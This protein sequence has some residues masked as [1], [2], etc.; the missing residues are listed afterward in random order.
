MRL[1]L[2]LLCGLMVTGFSGNASATPPPKDDLKEESAEKPTA[3]ATPSALD[4]NAPRQ[5]HFRVLPP[6]I[7]PVQGD[8]GGITKAAP[9]FKTTSHLALDQLSPREDY[10]YGP[11]FWNGVGIEKV[12]EFLKSPTPTVGSATFQNMILKAVLTPT[13]DT[14]ANIDL[15]S[16]R[17]SKLVDMGAY[18]DALNLYKMNENAPPSALAARAG[19]ESMLGDGQIAVACLEE[20]ALPAELKTDAPDLWKNLNILCQSLLSPVAGDDDALRLDNTVRIFATATSLPKPANLQDLNNFNLPALLAHARLGNLT[21]LMKDAPNLIDLQDKTLHALVSFH[22]SDRDL[23]VKFLNEALRRNLLSASGI[24]KELDFLTGQSSEPVKKDAKP[25]KYAAFFTQLRNKEFAATP[26]VIQEAVSLNALYLLIS[27]AGSFA[28]S[29][30]LNEFT[31]ADAKAILMLLTAANHSFPVKWV[32]T[33]FPGAKAVKHDVNMSGENLL[34]A[35]LTESQKA[36]NAAMAQI[37]AIRAVSLDANLVQDKEK[38]V[39]DNI[40]SLT[41]SGNYVMPMDENLR[42]LQKSAEEKQTGQVVID[43]VNVL[44][45][46]SMETIHPAALYR[47]FEAF[48]SAGLNEETD[49]LMREA[50]GVLMKKE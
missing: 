31:P 15:Y 27:K 48:D 17:L 26:A 28:E 6:T 11:D 32:E 40:L 38:S 49:S 1:L 10:A 42:N 33:A 4:P 29:E 7:K 46:A 2:A 16:L 50:L 36:D 14:S 20:K 45:G 43:S 44:K 35:F 19:V 25:D 3:P 39:Y 47:I 23:Q 24:K 21:P 9:E 12:A 8:S 30:N 37:I 34:T 41:A 18:D 22:A 5:T 13:P